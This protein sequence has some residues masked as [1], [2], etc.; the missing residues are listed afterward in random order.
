VS[1][2]KEKVIA[3]FTATLSLYRAD[4]TSNEK[5]KGDV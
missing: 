1:I 3:D 4:K 5:Q 2:H